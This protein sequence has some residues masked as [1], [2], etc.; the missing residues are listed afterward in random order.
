MGKI[1][2][3]KES[4]ENY[5]GSEIEDFLKDRIFPDSFIVEERELYVEKDDGKIY[6][7]SHPDI[8]TQPSLLPERFGNYGV[9]EVLCPYIDNKFDA[10]QI[11]NEAVI[12]GGTIFN[13]EYCEPLSCQYKNGELFV[14]EP[15]YY[16]EPDFILVK[17]YL[18]I[19]N[20]HYG[21]D[22]N[23]VSDLYWRDFDGVLKSMLVD[24]TGRIVVLYMSGQFT[25][26]KDSYGVNLSSIGGSDVQLLN[27][28]GRADV[29]EIFESSGGVYNFY[30]HGHQYKLHPPYGIYPYI[31][32]WHG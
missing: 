22:R 4:W 6:P 20:K 18:P 11:P 1:K 16:F 32:Q 26:K 8:S 27:N 19:S 12:I 2:S 14:H 5:N 17:Y 29:Y 3:I 13:D 7:T 28:Y 31:N 24:K 9:Y 15:Q 30:I 10:S 23:E 21:Y 25:V